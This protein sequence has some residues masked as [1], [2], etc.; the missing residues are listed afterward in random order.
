MPPSS[1]H[2]SLLPI[3]G[4]DSAVFTWQECG[5]VAEVGDFVWARV[6]AKSTGDD[7]HL[8]LP[9]HLTEIQVWPHQLDI[10][11]ALCLGSERSKQAKDYLNSSK[12]KAF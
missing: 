6:F 3:C 4:F 10:F 9:R 1:Q 7:V 5:G 12:H 2:A 8:L 11:P